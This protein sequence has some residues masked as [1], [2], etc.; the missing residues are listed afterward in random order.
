MSG[1]DYSAELANELLEEA[2]QKIEAL[3]AEN[4]RLR[5]PRRALTGTR[6]G[7]VLARHDVID[8]AAV[9]D[10][11]GYDG[12]R[13]VNSLAMAARELADDAAQPLPQ[14]PL[15]ADDIEALRNLAADPML[16]P[17]DRDVLDRVLVGATARPTV[18]PAVI[19]ALREAAAQPEY[20]SIGIAIRA[21]LEALGEG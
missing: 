1:Y 19:A 21:A 13:M 2:D 20:G 15:S 18:S 7:D 6:L 5:G 14:P 16:A 17:C 3:Q 8:A 12:Y 4:E 10:P 9:E 11:D